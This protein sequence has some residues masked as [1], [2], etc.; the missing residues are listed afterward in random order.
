MTRFWRQLWARLPENVRSSPV[1]RWLAIVREFFP[2]TALGVAMGVGAYAALRIFAYAELDL[3]WLVTGY[4][5]LGLCLLALLCVLPASVYI[6]FKLRSRRALT[7][8]TLRLETGR[9]L[10]SGFVLP[11]LRFV[12]FVQVRWDYLQPETDKLEPRPHAG[13]LIEHVALRERGRHSSIARRVVVQDPFG[14]ARV[15]LRSTDAREVIVMPELG[16]LSTLPSLSAPAGGDDL[17]HPMGLEDGDR[18]ELSRYAP[19]DPARYIHWKA[20]ARTRKLLVR[21]P[22]RALALARRCAAFYIAGPDD[23]ATAAVARLALERRL[24]GQE[25][26]F[27][28]DLAVSGTSRVDEAIT[29][30]LLSIKARGMSGVGLPGF[31]AQADKRGPASVIVFAP[32]EPGPWLQAVT[33]AASRRQ[34][35]V[36]IGVDGVARRIERPR[37]LRLLRREESAP[38][39]RAAAL[40]EVMLS[41]GRAR[42]L[43]TLLDRST[44]RML[45]EIGRKALFRAEGHDR[46]EQSDAG[47]SSQGSAA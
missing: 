17:P 3:V 12:P 29:E 11:S 36:V 18:L 6:F 7:H 5:A 46:P 14:L 25:W 1:W 23:D 16:G 32:P 41:L 39:A 45:G 38:G 27:G 47:H 4:A 19:G 2:L 35:R 30:L 8:D 28:T 42:V 15:E 33:R 13:Q 9:L 43:V 22:E 34:L 20:F 26:V 44:G 21:R 24:L 31:L 37:W 40:D 10:P